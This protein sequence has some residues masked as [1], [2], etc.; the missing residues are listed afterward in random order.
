MLFPLSIKL[1]PPFIIEILFICKDKSCLKKSNGIV[2]VL[3]VEI[4]GK[5]TCWQQVI[6]FGY[7]VQ[8]VSVGGGGVCNTKLL[9]ACLMCMRQ[10]GRLRETVSDSFFKISNITLYW[11]F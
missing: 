5:P 3:Y 4:F 10:C 2:S 9:C 7:L 1:V 11:G 6:E 8:T